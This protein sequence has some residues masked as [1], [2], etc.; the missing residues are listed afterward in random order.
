VLTAPL[1]WFNGYMLHLLRLWYVQS[2][3]WAVSRYVTTVRTLDGTFAV[4]DTF[5]NLGRP[6]YQ[7]Y[8][9]QGRV[10][11]VFLRLARIGFGIIMY[12]LAAVVYF[13]A[14]LMWLALP[15][16]FIAAIVGGFIGPEGTS[17][18]APAPAAQNGGPFGL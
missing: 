18:P 5:R 4:V 13:I 6:L 16:I 1:P 10:I 15:F 12:V 8:T 3:P 2:A 17:A 14:Y 11:G 9:W 7:D